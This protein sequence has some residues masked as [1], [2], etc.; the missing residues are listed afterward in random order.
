M[1]FIFEIID[2]SGRK[3]RLTKEQWK[4]IQQKHLNV[5]YYEIEVTIRNPLKILYD[6]EDDVWLYHAY[7]KHKKQASKYLREC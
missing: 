4:H 6:K 3:I 7:F 2:K 1:D 5:D